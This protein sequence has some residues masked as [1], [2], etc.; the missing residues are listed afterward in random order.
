[1]PIQSYAMPTHQNQQGRPPTGVHPFTGQPTNI[2]LAL[3][4][5]PPGWPRPP[6]NPPNDAGPP[7]GQ[8]PTTP[9]GQPPQT[10]PFPFNPQIPRPLFD[11]PPGGIRIIGDDSNLGDG[12][13]NPGYPPVIGN[14]G[15]GLGGGQQ[16]PSTELPHFGDQTP[17]R[18]NNPGVGTQPHPDFQQPPEPQP[19]PAGNINTSITPLL[20]YPEELMERARNQIV[21]SQAQSADPRWLMKR[22]ASPGRSNDAGIA[23]AATPF[24]A[25]SQF[26]GNQGYA[27]QTMGDFLAN[28][29][30]LMAGEIAREKEGL[31]LGNLLA[32]LREGNTASTNSFLSPLLGSLLR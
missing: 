10:Q 25:Q 21:A 18:P 16:Q 14:P 17:P 2:P 13:N 4:D 28:Q 31:G 29:E 15:G 22:F 6:A 30:S 19:M 24:L 12:G 27:N 20:V 3:H 8:V 23:S 26:L 32:R 5:P 7:P 1:M 11:P 9:Y